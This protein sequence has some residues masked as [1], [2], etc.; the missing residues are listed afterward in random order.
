ME[1]T[2]AAPRSKLSIVREH[3]AAGRWQEAI[4]LAAKF[5]DLGTQKEA[6]TRAHGCYSN[7]RFFTQLGIDCDAAKE[8][9][10]QALIARYHAA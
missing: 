6:I 2:L 3:M 7:P 4:R 5:P 9:G 10:K 1:T 8:A